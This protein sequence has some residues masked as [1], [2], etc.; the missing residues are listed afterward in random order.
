MEKL[1]DTV[2]TEEDFFDTEELGCA[3]NFRVRGTEEQCA[4]NTSR[5]GFVIIDHNEEFD[6][7]PDSL[8]QT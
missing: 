6:T 8:I 7:C 1:C 2:V 5:G 3:A 4:R